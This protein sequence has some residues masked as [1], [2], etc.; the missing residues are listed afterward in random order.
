MLAQDLG[1]GNVAAR[2]SRVRLHEIGPRIELEVIKV[3]GETMV[4]VGEPPLKV[5]Q[6]GGGQAGG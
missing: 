1:K 6:Q 4:K 5:T 2:Q 3:W